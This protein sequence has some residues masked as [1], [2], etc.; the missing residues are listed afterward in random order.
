[1]RSPLPLLLLTL[2]TTAASAQKIELKINA[3]ANLTILPD[4]NNRI[5][6]ADGFIVPGLITPA[7]ARKLSITTPVSATRNRPGLMLE[8][9][10][11]KKLSSRWK[12]S[13]ALGFI[14]MKYDYD[15]HIAQSFYGNNFYLGEKAAKYGETRLSY[16]SA[17]PANVA[18]TF[19]RFSLQGGPVI[20]YLIGKQYTNNV[21]I[22]SNT[23]EAV[24]AFWEEKGDVQ[25]WLF[26]AHLN[27]RYEI[28]PRLE[29]MLGGQYFFNSIYKRDGTYEPLYNKSKPLQ[30][31]L[32]VSYRILPFFRKV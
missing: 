10:A 20:G 23:G 8:A 17:R 11:G 5:Y 6:I 25:Q 24:G 31:Q 30:V 32:G 14:R 15:T 22:H 27:A 12:L 26:G 13:V 16:L 9:E 7:N 21:V 29:V 28:I 18:V 2:S 19:N 4:F 1:M 3:A